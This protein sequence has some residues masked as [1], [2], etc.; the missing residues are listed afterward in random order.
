MKEILLVA[1]ALFF[2]APAMAQ[3]A[4]QSSAIGFAIRSSASLQ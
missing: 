2:V 4:H 3:H 1:S